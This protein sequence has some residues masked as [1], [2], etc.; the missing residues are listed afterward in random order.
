MRPKSKLKDVAK[1]V[2]SFTLGTVMA[3]TGAFADLTLPGAD[4]RAEAAETVTEETVGTD[5]V[6]IAMKYLGYGYSQSSR[7]GSNGTFDC[8]GLVKKVLEEAGFSGV[9][10][11]TSDWQN[12]ITSGTLSLSY[13]GQYK[14]SAGFNGIKYASSLEEMY[15]MKD[16]DANNGY[17]IITRTAITTDRLQD[18]DLPAGSIVVTQATASSAAHAMIVIGDYSKQMPEGVDSTNFWE[19]YW[20]YY[21]DVVGAM[22]D[23]YPNLKSRLSSGRYVGAPS[24]YSISTSN[25]TSAQ[26]MDWPSGTAF[27]AKQSYWMMLNSTA[28]SSPTSSSLGSGTWAIDAASTTYGVRITNKIGGKGG[29]TVPAYV[30]VWPENKEYSASVNFHKV[31]QNGSNV[32]GAEFTAYS[33]EACTN[34]VATLDYSS[35]GKYSWT[36]QWNS[37]EDSQTKRIYYIKETKVP[38]GYTAD[39]NSSGQ[40]ATWKVELDGYNHT[41]TYY[42]RYGTSGSWT[43]VADGAVNT[44]YLTVLNKQKEATVNLSVHKTDDGGKKIANV[45]FTIYQNFDPATGALSNKLGTVI[46]DQNGEGTFSYELGTAVYS[47]QPMYIKETKVPDGYVAG[48]DVVY[49]RPIV[50]YVQ[51]GIYYYNMNAAGYYTYNSDGSYTLKTSDKD[52]VLS[53]VGI[54][55]VLTY[56][57]DN[58]TMC[59]GSYEL[60][61]K[62]ENDRLASHYAYKT[63]GANTSLDDIESI[64]YQLYRTSGKYTTPQKVGAEKTSS[65]KTGT[66][67]FRVDWKDLAYYDDAGNPYSYYAIETKVNGSAE[68]LSNYIVTYDGDS[69]YT[70]VTNTINTLHGS[71]S[72]EKINDIGNAVTAT[73]NV[74][75]DSVCSNKLGSFITVNGSGTYTLPSW[76]ASEGL[77][78]TVYFKE[79]NLDAEGYVTINGVKYEGDT[80]VYRVVV[81]GTTSASTASAYKIYNNATGEELAGNTII[82]YETT[83]HS[84]EKKFGEGAE[85]YIDSVTVQLMQG[86]TVYDEKIISKNNAGKIS[87][88]WSSLPKY[89]ASGN[90]YK[91]WVKETAVNGRTDLL[92]RF[93]VTTNNAGTSVMTST[94]ITNTIKTVDHTFYKRFG[95]T[96]TQ[97][98]ITSI[99]VQLYQNGAKYGNE[100]IVTAASKVDSTAWAYKWSGLPQYDKAGNAY[101]YYAQEV[102]VSYKAADGTSHT[103][104]GS[105]ID[106]YFIRTTSNAG[107]QVLTSTT[108]TNTLIPLYGAVSI[109]KVNAENETVKIKGVKY[110]VYSDQECKN[111]I[112][113]YL[114]TDASGV[115]V[116]TVAA[117]W[118][119]IN[120][121]TKTVYI[122]EYSTVSPYILDNTIYKVVIT[123]STVNASGSSCTV[124]ADGKDI[125]TSIKQFKQDNAEQYGQIIVS[126][127]GEVLTGFSGTTL[128]GA[129]GVITGYNNGTFS[130]TAQKMAG[131]AFKLY[132]VGNISNKAGTVIY[133]DGQEIAALTTDANGMATFTGLPL[134]T[135]RIVETQAP[136]G[137]TIPEIHEWT[138]T[139]TYAGQTAA[140]TSEAQDVNDAL[141][142]AAVSVV[143]IDSTT[144]YGLADTYFGLYAAKDIKNAAG[145]VIV[146]ADELISVVKTDADGKCTFLNG[147][148][149]DIDIP[150]GSYYVKEIQTRD[151]YILSDERYDF[152]FSFTSQTTYTKTFTHTFADERMSAEISIQKVDKKTE[153]PVPEGDGSLDGA[154]YYLY[155]REDI[156][157]PDGHTGV[158]YKAGDYVAALTTADGGKASID[159]LYLGKYYVKEI[160]PPKGYLL[161]NTEYDLVVVSDGVNHVA[162][163]ITVYKNTEAITDDTDVY[164][165]PIER[166]FAIMK[167]S[168]GNSDTKLEG[169][170]GAG[171][172][173]Y[174]KSTLVY[175]ADGSVDY[176]ASPKTVITAD[177]GTEGFT[178]DVFG[179]NGAL[180]YAGYLETIPIPY[181]EYLVHESTVPENES[182]V[183]DFTV[184][185]TEAD[186]EKNGNGLPVAN[187]ATPQA[188]RYLF[189]KDFEAKLKLIKK[190]SYT[191]KEIALS[192]TVF[193][194]YDVTNGEYVGYWDVDS[195]SQKSYIDSWTTNDEGFVIIGKALPV[196]TY[197]IEEQLAPDG[198]Y[199]SETAEGITSQFSID[200]NSGFVFEGS[201]VD[202]YYD[203]DLNCYILPVVYYDDEVRGVI[204]VYKEG[205]VLVSYNKETKAF[206]W[207][208]T[209]LAGAEYDVYAEG[210]IYTPDHQTDENGN[211][212]VFYKNGELVGHITTGA[213]GHGYLENLP[214]GTYKIV[215][216]KAPGGYLLGDTEKTAQYAALAYA[217]QNVRVVYDSDGVENH[218]FNARPQADISI[219][220][221]ERDEDGSTNYNVTLAGTA[222]DFITTT[223]IKNYKGE[224]IISAG[225][226][227]ASVT[228]GADGVAAVDTAINIPF[229]SYAFV[230]TAVTPGYVR[231]Q[232][233]ISVS[234]AYVDQNTPVIS[235]RA[236]QA[237]DFIKLDTSK[238]DIANSA[239]VEWA[240][241]AVVKANDDGTETIIDE[242]ISTDVP[243]RINRIPA[244]DYILREI[245]APTQN[246]YVKAQDLPFTVTE[247]AIVQ[248]LVMYDDHTELHIKKTDLVT[249]EPV[250]GA[251]LQMINADGSIYA[252]W[253]TDG[254][255]FVLEY[256]PVGTYTL[257]EIQAPGGF[258][259]AEDV[260]VTVKDTEDIQ[261]VEMIDYRTPEAKTTARDTATGTHSMSYG[262]TVTLTDTVYYKYLIP[263][264]EY[265]VTGT[266]MVK[267]TG[268]PLTDKDGHIITATTTFI[269]ES[270]ING[271]VELE[272]TIDTTVLQG[273]TLVVF[274]NIEENGQTIII[275]ADIEDED[276]TVYV[277]DIGTTATDVK[278]EDHIGSCREA[279]TIQDV[280]AYTNLV[281][282]K[283]YTISGVLYSRQTGKPLTGADG[284]TC[285]A[286]KTFTAEKADGSVTIQFVIN[287]T[288]LQGQTLVAF[289]TLTYKGVEIA[290]HADIEDEGQTVHI[291][292]I[293]T[294][295]T[296]CTTGTHDTLFQEKV[297]VQDVVEYTNLVPGK[298]YVLTGTLYLKSTGEPL[299]DGEGNPY[300]ATK[301]FI[302]ES[303][304]GTETLAFTVDTTKIAGEKI[305][306]FET[307]TYKG[308]EIAIEADLEDADQTIE[309]PKA[310]KIAVM[311]KGN[312]VTGTREV[313]TKY[314]TVNKLTFG[315]TYLAGVEFTVYADKECTED[316]T[317][318]VTN[319]DGLAVSK[320]LAAGTY[321]IVETYT[322]AG[323]AKDD[324][325][326]TVV[327]G[328]IAENIEGIEY[329]LDVTKDIVNHLCSSTLNIYKVG[330]DMVGSEKF[331]PLEGVYFGVY[332]DKDIKNVL[333]DVVIKADDCIAIIKTNSE[334]IATMTENLPSGKYYYKEL[335]TRDDFVLDETEY[336]F[337]VSLENDDAVIEVNKTNP[338]VNY[339]KSGTLTV[340]KVDQD[341]NPLGAGVKFLLTCIET[342]ETW[343]LVT[344]A[345]GVV[346]IG[347]LPIG[348]IEDGKW[349]YYT[350]TLR[351]T[352]PLDHYRLDDTVYTF[353]FTAE[354]TAADAV[355]RS[356]TIRNVILGIE[357][358]SMAGGITMLLMAVF[359]LIMAMRKGKGRFWYKAASDTEDRKR[360]AE[361]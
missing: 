37:A 306:A 30:I 97:N 235:I 31:N 183:K 236:E 124:T 36:V 68:N 289:E 258:E 47:S 1:R 40:T 311:K 341:D 218:F 22:A 245:S 159:G 223:D 251:T 199:N 158:V 288:V 345:D 254:T 130:Y 70:V 309:V 212:T 336:R 197:R 187:K 269:P 191:G 14:D 267:E 283:E 295:F 351:E 248:E 255:D 93:T 264:K 8:S 268:E 285:T 279:V 76:K 265:T 115:A 81:T 189:D 107:T 205:E 139:L 82:N 71:F 340:H 326:Y 226:V 18:A 143:K 66:Q 331:I 266:V 73:F 233:P 315:Y 317:K 232:T 281:P 154:V 182:P 169:L 41:T 272:F 201:S 338:L 271:S 88:T 120:G 349:V 59:A 25:Y 5:I 110:G 324:T 263:G 291:P 188:Y 270:K 333:G 354:S 237:N 67:K 16:D 332:A 77:T 90:A 323:Y 292:E 359:M 94:T 42:K 162:T 39:S 146:K 297:T 102:S 125:G 221:Y 101:K 240:Q 347:D 11:N 196:G 160:T 327:I 257:R 342:G 319:S 246:G 119:K 131:A 222:F 300:T 86:N 20:T 206:T 19:N 132:A 296:D 305:V 168:G 12:Q 337:E 193:K 239:E 17:A 35:G 108:V 290:V 21:D 138:K 45:E 227:L 229:G 260:T 210:D 313:K 310:G 167:F 98:A 100:V 83:S 178:A 184:K 314:G 176:A 163:T 302:A 195:S 329:V 104:T 109:E 259:I 207:V 87:Y 244:G 280:V 170:N 3:V 161:D 208:K 293:G 113:D 15:Q 308:V 33:N 151:G 356:F 194:I 80:N 328:G 361:G 284:N 165:S 48:K 56:P 55:E 54:T 286:S 181:G 225:T 166:P 173:A 238:L 278:T 112:G 185:I 282:G 129:D 230:E 252:E 256:I 242:W 301:T 261:T 186:T 117:P 215:E 92:S 2:T 133:T 353:S 43:K 192:G 103:L 29:A 360:I 114:T 198:Y 123:G 177:G 217:G 312:V 307:L 75:S 34:K 321:Y 58:P 250:I 224:V 52:E 24:T 137:Q 105:S 352:K 320:D 78:K 249:G 122:K 339:A 79:A 134:G 38:S 144:S 84:F 334:G 253:I 247:T 357:D 171:F 344:G 275:H 318:I 136:E 335:K 121:A 219:V 128:T 204:E 274:E 213:D 155:A 10:G 141:A 118:Y 32:S 26:V 355:Y 72:L 202:E 85:N 152:T 276:Q 135:Y 46:T 69:D 214:L 179:D 216:T 153:L 27:S 262:K 149:K 298:E 74:Y 174:L 13:N 180:L 145:T 322:P 127:Y 89:D 346:S 350:Y 64:T 287:T 57:E 231:D 116:Y 330:T 209:G 142:D 51:H 228:T 157:H 220:K 106:T 343:T 190:D 23:D 211:R 273:Q 299:L 53:L 203:A 95:N 304:N 9:P 277:P 44:Y 303:E 50:G 140:I 60:S 156:I 28:S 4:T 325:V 6:N 243:H 126:K 172:T 164:E 316:V 62:V 234:F 148:G 150:Y 348:Y 91:Y 7:D 294:T 61:M 96:D 175:K 49:I 358:Y 111:R 63:V 65:N 200:L 147:E 99:K 241:M